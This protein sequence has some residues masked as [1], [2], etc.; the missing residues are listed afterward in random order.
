MHISN[1]VHEKSNVIAKNKI[2]VIDDDSSIRML[3]EIILKKNYEVIA[4]ENGFEALMWME[5]N[6]IPDLIIVDINMPRIN[7]YQFIHNLKKSGYYRDIPII[8]LSGSLDT[9]TKIKCYDLGVKDYYL[10]PFNPNELLVK[11]NGILKNQQDLRY[12]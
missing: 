1:N 5:N 3:L 4:V 2:L 6:S 10:K 12:V 8:V 7:G 9:E 11:V